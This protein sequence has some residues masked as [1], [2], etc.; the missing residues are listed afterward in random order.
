[1]REDEG[2]VSVGFSLV[3]GRV[4]AVSE[5]PGLRVG[6]DALVADEQ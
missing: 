6:R 5:K 4:A 1:M 3:S 2:S